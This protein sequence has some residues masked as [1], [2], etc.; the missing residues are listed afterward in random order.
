MTP[1]EKARQQI[2]RQLADCGWA[3]QDYRQMNIS[4]SQDQRHS[5]WP[6][7]RSCCGLDVGILDDGCGDDGRA[8]ARC[9][10]LVSSSGAWDTTSAAF[11]P[12]LIAFAFDP[13]AQRRSAGGL[14]SGNASPPQRQTAFVGIAAQ[15]IV[16]DWTLPGRRVRLSVCPLASAASAGRFSIDVAS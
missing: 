13:S 7:C 14:A 6:A 3:V 8:V 2:D 5:L 15:C 1:K 12:R 10:R 16:A 9:W 4:A 11:S